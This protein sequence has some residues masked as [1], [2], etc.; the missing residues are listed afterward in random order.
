VAGL[1]SAVVPGLGR[2]YLGRW[3]D[4]VMS[5]VLVGL[6]GGFAWDG[7]RERGVSSVRGWLLGSMAAF[8]YAGNIYGSAVG[9][10]VVHQEA[11]KRLRAEIRGAY[12][13]RLLR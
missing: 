1:L 12:Q 11:E 8:L 4:G 6:P 3:E 2:V 13:D 9:A 7:F 5:L 10:E